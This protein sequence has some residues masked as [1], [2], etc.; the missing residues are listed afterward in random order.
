[1]DPQF[2]F[3]S[4]YDLGL[5]GIERLHPFDSRK[6]GR[7]WHLAN[8]ATR[9]AVEAR[10]Q[11]VDRAIADEEL[12]YVHTEEYLRSL[13]STR[14]VAEVLEL[15]P[16][17]LLP[18]FMLRRGLLEPMRLATRGTCLAGELAL[19]HGLALNLAGGYHHARPDGGEGFCVYND[20]AV[21]VA[22]LRATSRLAADAPV[23]YVDL[24][25]HMGN[26]VARAFAEDASV[27]LLDMYNAEIYPDDPEAAGRID[28]NLGLK[29]KTDGEAYL[30]ILARAL[31]DV[32]ARPVRPA[33]AIYNA[34]TDVLDTDPLGGL[35]LD[36]DAIDARDRLVLARF[37]SQGVPL[38][39]LPSGGYTETSHRLLGRLLV[40]ALEAR[41]STDEA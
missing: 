14:V 22:H 40:R 26:G 13:A 3:H 10:T 15:P 29:A 17:R 35:R 34:G 19:D 2:V 37:V 21:M 24:D 1:M 39:V 28:V 20:I 23:L 30:E 11:I 6:Y 12:R 16:L 5:L 25:A 32:L 36:E 27:T 31:D 18:A 38:V 9:G 33:L 41:G 4:R 8:V 7:A